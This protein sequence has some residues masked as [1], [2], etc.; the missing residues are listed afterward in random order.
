VNKEIGERAVTVVKE[1]T[2]EE[3][4]DEIAR[5]LAGYKITDASRASALELITSA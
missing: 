3:K 2:A 5:M 4:V 1:L